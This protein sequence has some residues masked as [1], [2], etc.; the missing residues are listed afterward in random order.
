MTLFH[1]RFKADRINTPVKTIEKQQEGLQKIGRYMS[2]LQNLINASFAACQLLKKDFIASENVE[3][4][5]IIKECYKTAKA[6]GVD[7]HLNISDYNYIN[8]EKDVTKPFGLP[9]DLQRDEWNPEQHGTDLEIEEE[10]DY[11]D[12][13]HR[14]WLSSNC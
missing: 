5:Q 9:S 8:P 7:F 6:H 4:Q 1:E 3:I 10:Y 12:G 11:M 14:E 13:E 2:V